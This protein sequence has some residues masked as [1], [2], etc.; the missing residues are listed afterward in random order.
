MISSKWQPRIYALFLA[1]IALALIIGGIQLITLG[2]SFY[3]GLAGLAL[4]IVSVLLWRQ[5]REA[6]LIYGSIIAIT[7]I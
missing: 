5:R 6:L 4:V 2:G 1:A 3:Y 7:V